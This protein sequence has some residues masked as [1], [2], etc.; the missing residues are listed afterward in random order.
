[1]TKSAELVTRCALAKPAAGACSWCGEALPEGRRMWC[2]DR[3]ATVFWK[4][5]WWSRARRA[6]KRRDKYA[7]VRC[8]GGRPLEVN[9][10]E[11]CLGAHGEI[12]CA[13]HL[14]N[15]ETLCAPCHRAHTASAV[16]VPGRVRAD[17]D[18]GEEERQQGVPQA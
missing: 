7:C 17:H 14:A 3:C 4:N 9:H 16:G 6:A 8:G 15:L 2:R 13:H 12:S 11:P 1:M 5:H 18:R 10:I